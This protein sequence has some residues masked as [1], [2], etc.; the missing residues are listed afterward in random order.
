MIFCEV[1]LQFDLIKK[2]LNVALEIICNEELAITREFLQKKLVFEKYKSVIKY[3]I[4]KQLI[5]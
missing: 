5:N 3:C 1:N 2:N 4:F